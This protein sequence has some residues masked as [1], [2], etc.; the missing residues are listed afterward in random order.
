M[1]A[2]QFARDEIP[3]TGTAIE[4]QS[5]RDRA[6]E[7]DRAAGAREVADTGVG[8]R[9]AEIERCIV[10]ANQAGRAGAGPL[11]GGV[12][13]RYGAAVGGGDRTGVG[14]GIDG[15]AAI[16]ESGAGGDID[17]AVV[18][19]GDAERSVKCIAGGREVDGA[20]VDGDGRDPA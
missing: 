3:G 1:P 12:A 16:N 8:E 20:V 11:V 13:K 10:D 6:G 17:G 15:V 9:A 18:G 7:I 14:E 19:A 5:A 4:R 2:A